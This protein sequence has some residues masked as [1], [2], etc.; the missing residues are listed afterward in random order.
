MAKGLL[1]QASNT[2]GIIA[3]NNSKNTLTATLKE[4]DVEYTGL[5]SNTTITTVD[6]VNKT[7]KVD[8]KGVLYKDYDKYIVK[9]T[10]EDIVLLENE[11][12]F[13][14]SNLKKGIF[15][16]PECKHGYVSSIVIETKDQV[17]LIEFQNNSKYEL[18][19]V[20]EQE[21][22]SIE[23]IT[24]DLNYEYT[25]LLLCNGRYINIYVQEINLN[26]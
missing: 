21:L 8:L 18:R 13:V 6:N 12:E 26:N 5:E 10:I 19:F 22:I 9:N 16:I 14:Y 15:I 17:P 3:N 11:S 7:V 4:K 2:V 20:K 24:L 1:G 23:D 25:F